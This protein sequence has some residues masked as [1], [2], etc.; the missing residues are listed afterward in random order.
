MLEWQAMEDLVG[1]ERARAVM[2]FKRQD[3]YK[4]LYATVMENREQMEKFLKRY[5]VKW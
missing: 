1:V 5:S 2:E 3:H 4:T